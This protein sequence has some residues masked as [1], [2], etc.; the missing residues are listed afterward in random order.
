MAIKPF[1]PIDP[2]DP[3]SSIRIVRANLGVATG[4][5]GLCSIQNPFGVAAVVMEVILDI[6]T[7][8]TGSATGDF[9]VAATAISADTLVDGIDIGAAAIQTTATKELLGDYATATGNAAGVQ[10]IAATGYVTGTASA[11][12]AGLVGTIAVIFV[13]ADAVA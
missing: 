4:A 13:K 1:T 5:A 6:T 2:V 7:P 12:P 8:A 3:D 9:G 11:D 10:S